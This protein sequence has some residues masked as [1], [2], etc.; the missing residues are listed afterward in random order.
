MANLI[1][2]LYQ[3]TFKSG[4]QL[5]AA[6]AQSN[7]YTNLVTNFLAGGV[8]GGA[9]NGGVYNE[10]IYD[11]NGEC[12]GA[13]SYRASAGDLELTSVAQLD[14]DPHGN[15]SGSPTD[16]GRVIPRGNLSLE[17]LWDNNFQ[18]YGGLRAATGEIYPL[19][20]TFIGVEGDA[21]EKKRLDTTIVQQREVK[22]ALKYYRDIALSNPSIGNIGAT[23][24]YVARIPHTE[25]PLRLLDYREYNLNQSVDLLGRGTAYQLLNYYPLPF[26]SLAK[27]VVSNLNKRGFDVKPDPIIQLQHETARHFGKHAAIL[28]PLLLITRPFAGVIEAYVQDTINQNF[29]LLFE[30]ASGLFNP[31]APKP[32]KA[33]GRTRSQYPSNFEIT[34]AGALD[35]PNI[36]RP[37]FPG[38]GRQEMRNV[39]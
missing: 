36:I 37:N 5:I 27:N 38:S 30:A 25:N 24:L 6:L 20:K 32:K 29:N 34:E 8:S 26:F 2:E 28:Y 10:I 17:R 7:P 4:E 21:T 1:N 12:L 31:E 13:R 19:N 23:S 22:E 33:Q 18:M 35:E 15:L 9:I 11:Q 3:A 14:V 16:S 39:A